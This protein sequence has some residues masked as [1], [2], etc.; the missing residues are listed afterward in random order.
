MCKSNAF[1]VMFLY[2]CDADQTLIMVIENGGPEPGTN[3]VHCDIYNV[4]YFSGN[5]YKV[6]RLATL[7]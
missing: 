2:Y 7:G 6:R 4:S 3:T 5:R 1:D